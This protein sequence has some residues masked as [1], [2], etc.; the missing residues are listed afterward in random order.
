MEYDPYAFLEPKGGKE[1]KKSSSSAIQ[2]LIQRGSASSAKINSLKIKQKAK[3]LKE[4][5]SIP[6]I[7]QKSRKIAQ[8]MK[9]ER[10]DLITQMQYKEEAKIPDP[11]PEPVRMSVNI[12]KTL[13]LAEQ[14]KAP[15]LKN[16]NIAERSK[17]W[18]EQK[19]KKIAEQQKAKKETE[20]DGCTFKPKKNFEAEF[21]RKEPMKVAQER[22]NSANN[23]QEKKAPVKKLNIVEKEV[24]YDNIAFMLKG[25]DFV[26]EEQ[27]KK[28]AE[29]NPPV[30]IKPGF[31]SEMSKPKGK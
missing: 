30:R 7:N 8:G 22:R 27:I 14:E 1:L 24:Q 31:L 12:L 20:L 4:M 23:L 16:M 3:E 15:D 18:K 13:E 28:P 19:E 9:R 21:E 29:K 11:D 6:I 17:Y 2:S 25:T 26:K 5:R 10:L